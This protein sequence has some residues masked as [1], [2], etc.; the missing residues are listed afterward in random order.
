[1]EFDMSS[2]Q[3]SLSAFDFRDD[4]TSTTAAL[5]GAVIAAALAIFILGS[6]LEGRPGGALNPPGISLEGP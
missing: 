1:M 5:I 2:I 4:R 6:A 3:G